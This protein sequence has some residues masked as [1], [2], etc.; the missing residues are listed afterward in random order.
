LVGELTVVRQNKPRQV[1]VSFQ[2]SRVGTFHATLNITF[3]DKSRPNNVQ[4]FRVSRELRGRA[5]L[6]D[7]P[8]SNGDASNTSTVEDVMGSEEGTG[9]T[10]SHD[11][12]VDFDAESTQLDGS[13]TTETKEVVIT[14]SSTTPP[15]TFKAARVS[16]TDDSVTE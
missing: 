7:S 5:A 10:V 8:A 14:K 2:A 6:P 3:S 1:L 16:S 11:Y 12:G 15:V 4:E 13:F 9:I